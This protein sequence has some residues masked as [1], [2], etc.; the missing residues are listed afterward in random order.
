[1]RRTW[2]IALLGAAHFVLSVSLARYLGGLVIFCGDPVLVF[3]IG[4]FWRIFWFPLPLAGYY[5]LPGLPV[6][7]EYVLVLANSTLFAVAVSSLWRWWRR[8]GCRAPSV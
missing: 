6:W 3:I 7:G 8:R 2:P 5:C 4:W 1:M